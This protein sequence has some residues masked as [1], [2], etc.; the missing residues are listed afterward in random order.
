MKNKVQEQLIKYRDRHHLTQF[1]M[2]DLLGVKRATL[3]KWETGD[4]FPKNNAL[5]KI[6]N[7]LGIPIDELI[8]DDGVTQE[9]S[10]PSQDLKVAFYQ[11]QGIVSDEQQKMVDDFIDMLK[12]ANSK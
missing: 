5:I 7:T 1:E 9:A 11:Q 2:A 4:T 12:K 10:V 3:S 8:R 6:S